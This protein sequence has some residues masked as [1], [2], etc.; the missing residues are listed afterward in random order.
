MVQQK[1]S[2]LF[3]HIKQHTTAGHLRHVYIIVLLQ[4]EAIRYVLYPE[5]LRYEGEARLVLDITVRDGLSHSGFLLSEL[6][7]CFVHPLWE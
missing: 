3:K 5:R 2:A 6:N 4:P 1:S 7:C